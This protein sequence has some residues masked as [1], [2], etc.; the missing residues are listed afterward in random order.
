MTRAH[1]GSTLVLRNGI[2]SL[3]EGM[4]LFPLDGRVFD[5]T[6]TIPVLMNTVTYKSEDESKFCGSVAVEDGTTNLLP[7][8]QAECSVLPRI[9]Y[10][11]VSVDTTHFLSG[12]SS[13]KVTWDGI[14]PYGYGQYDLNLTNGN[15]YT[16][17]V[18]AYSE[19]GTY[20]K[21][22]IQESAAPWRTFTSGRIYLPPNNW[23]RLSVTFSLQSDFVQPARF[24]M[25]VASSSTSET[26]VKNPIW[27][28]CAMVEQKDHVTSWVNGTRS[29]GNL[30]Y[31]ISSLG[32]RDAGCIS[33]WILNSDTMVNNK[34]AGDTPNNQYMIK[35]GSY[36]YND[37][38]DDALTLRIENVTPRKFKFYSTSTTAQGV[39]SVDEISSITT[40]DQYGG[41][42]SWNHFVIQWDKNGLP[43][44]YKKELYINGVMEAVSDTTSLPNNILTYLHLGQWSDNG[45][46]MPCTQFEQL[47]IHPSKGFS[48]KEIQS[49]YEA[50]APFYDVRDTILFY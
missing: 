43:S 24:Q 42:G 47:A 18:Y 37:W 12:G 28:D 48:P 4:I 1:E 27:Y 5:T 10:A 49:W 7:S 46:L 22:S 34:A 32:M 2:K 39:H 50:Q 40:V 45:S 25:Y 41:V 35:L 8:N 9:V 29:V 15:T 16:A 6:N 36:K 23:V 17:S 21:L 38:Y 19:T 14:N 20:A 26:L 3:P 33:C 44:G 31:D 11:T 30:K 13:L